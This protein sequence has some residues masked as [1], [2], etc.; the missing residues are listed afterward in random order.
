MGVLGGVFGP[1]WGAFWRSLVVFGRPLGGLW[2][3]LG[4]LLGVSGPPWATL[5]GQGAPG[6]EESPPKTH[7][8]KVFWRHFESLGQKVPYGVL[9]GVLLGRVCQKIPKTRFSFSYG[10]S[11]LKW[12]IG[13]LG[14][15]VFEGL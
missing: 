1:L 10:D 9:V 5:G 4:A 8:W 14:V 13:G 2:A 12:H 11:K 3:S 7:F 6:S 15:K